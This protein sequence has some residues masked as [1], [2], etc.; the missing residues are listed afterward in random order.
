MNDEEQRS[1]KTDNQRPSLLQ[2]I[3]NGLSKL[4]SSDKV[5]AECED[6]EKIVDRP[7]DYHT[8][9]RWEAYLEN[10]FEQFFNTKTSIRPPNLFSKIGH[11]GEPISLITNY[12]QAKMSNPGFEKCFV[13][14]Y[15]DRE[16]MR[17]LVR[18]QLDFNGYF[19]ANGSILTAKRPM[20]P[21]DAVRILS[22]G[23]ITVDS[24]ESTKILNLILNRAMD[25]LRL[26]SFGQTYY[27]ATTPVS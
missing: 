25:I 20:P 22:L 23:D 18:K 27:D 10:V 5:P 9:A 17:L 1:G 7:Y 15:M 11:I 2:Y 24:R 6:H 4:V 12:I 16:E 26:Q 13:D 21:N 14:D 19:F 3:W 8:D